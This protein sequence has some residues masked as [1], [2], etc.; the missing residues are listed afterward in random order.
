MTGTDEQTQIVLNNNSLIHFVQLLNHP[1]EKI[2]KVSIIF[3]RSY[4]VAR[5]PPF[6]FVVG[7]GEGAF[8]T[9]WEIR[10]AIPMFLSRN[11]LG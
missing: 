6:E 3:N 7:G 11:F 8:T 10:G 5:V 1:K 4:L 2:I 9:Y